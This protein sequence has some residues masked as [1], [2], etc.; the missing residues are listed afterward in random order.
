N[1]SD[2]KFY[3]WYKKHSKA[4]YDILTKITILISR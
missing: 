2:K 4:F 1:K 3:T